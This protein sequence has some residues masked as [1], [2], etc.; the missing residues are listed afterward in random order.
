MSIGTSVLVV[1]VDLVV[2]V[3]GFVC[4]RVMGVSAQVLC[5]TSSSQ[6][7][8]SLPQPNMIAVLLELSSEVED[9]GQRMID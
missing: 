3:F 6:H 1:I 4:H 8:E 5:L 9:R 2:S 7:E